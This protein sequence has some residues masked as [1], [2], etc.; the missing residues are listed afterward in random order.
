[1]SRTNFIIDAVVR[2]PDK[3]GTL[4]SSVSVLGCGMRRALPFVVETAESLGG[5]VLRVGISEVEAT[6]FCPREDSDKVFSALAS[7]VTP[8]A[9]APRSRSSE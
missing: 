8:T 4:F 2:R 3:S 1:M 7:L 6:V 9:R 5:R